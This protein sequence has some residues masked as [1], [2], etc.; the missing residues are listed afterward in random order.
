MKKLVGLIIV[1]GVYVAASW[2][3]GVQGEKNIRQ[4]MALAEA[5]SEAQ[6]VKLILNDYQRG[7]FFSEMNISAVYTSPAIPEMRFKADSVSKIQH[8]P[9]YFTG[10]VGVGLFSSVS[11]LK[12]Q[13]GS[14]E[15]DQKLQ[16]MFG[17]S[18]GEFVTVGHFNSTYTSTWS[19]PAIDTAG[20]NGSQFTLAPSRI[21]VSGRYDQL[22]AA[23]SFEI[24]ALEV[25]A[26]N[27]RVTTTPIIGSFDTDNIAD[28]VNITNLDMLVETISYSDRAMGQSFSIDQLKVVQTQKLINEKIDTVVSFTAEKL[29]SPV[30][31]SALSYVLTLN[32]LDPVAMQVW[33]DFNQSLQQD[34]ENL[35][36]EK[37]AELLAAVLQE[38][39][40]FKLDLGAGFMGGNALVNL[41]AD[42]KALP[43]GQQVLDI[44]DP[45]DYFKLADADALITVSGSIVNQTPLGMMVGQY[46]NTYITLEGDNYVVR[47]SLKNGRLM[48]G[49]TEI[50]VE[51]LLMFLP[52]SDA[53]AYEADMSEEHML[54]EEGLMAEEVM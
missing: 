30:E 10:G 24:G 49:N 39:L 50:P 44:N 9:I 52:N 38:G 5:Q 53:T 8:G 4:Q 29:N 7:I 37:L 40:Q 35:D 11:T 2:Y 51:T 32:Q 46:L 25:I 20:S 12:I 16:E 23:G 36:E 6:G 1:V 43:D 22:D 41:T 42:Y 28:Q 26:D 47:A 13:T 33:A 54:H 27:S 18:I 45:V 21:K 34:P 17:E 19:L 3:T 14:E 31:I 48:V 15:I